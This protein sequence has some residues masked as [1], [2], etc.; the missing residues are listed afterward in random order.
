MSTTSI[1]TLF[2]H[3]SSVS[4]NCPGRRQVSVARWVLGV[5]LI[6]AFTLMPSLARAADSASPAAVGGITGRVKNAVTGLYLSNARVAV[7]GINSVA[8]TDNAGAYNLVGI[9]SGSVVLEVNYTDLDTQTVSVTVQPGHIVQQ[10]IELT[11]R[12]RYGLDA[13][14]L[15]LDP[16]VVGTNREADAE[17][18]AVNEQR[19]AANIKN[20]V[21]TDAM[22]D[23]V[24]QSAGEFL[25]YLPGVS[26]EYDAAEV[27]GISVRGIGSGMT[28]VESD[29]MSSTSGSHG[30]GRV[31][32]L[33][34]MSIN[35][36]SRIELSK[37]PTPSS[38]ADSL[39]GT[40]NM[41]SKTAFERD[42]DELRYGVNV[43]G[44]LK[45]LSLQRTP[46][47]YGDEKT[48]KILPGYDLD[49]TKLIG[50]NFGV[51]LTAMSSSSHT[52]FDFSMRTWSAAG[53][54]TNASFSQPYLQSVALQGSK[55]YRERSLYGVR[56][57]WRVT[58]HAVLTFG[59]RRS[60]SISARTGRNNI[61]FNVGT[62]GT[63]SVA[64][65]VAMA[66]GPTFTRGA[67]GRGS[68]A[69]SGT[70]QFGDIDGDTLD[71]HYRFDD[72]RWK[73][74]GSLLYGDSNARLQPENTFSGVSATLAVPV[75]V[76]YADI[77]D[78]GTPVIRVFNNAN[79]EVDFRDINNY[80][81][82]TASGGQNQRVQSATKS[83]KLDLG[84]RLGVFRFPLTVQAGGM[85]RLQLRDRR[86][87]P[88]V[89]TLNFVGTNHPATPYLG[90]SYREYQTLDFGTIPALSA[91]RG[92]RAFA[93][94]P[95]LFSQTAAQIV[96]VETA[97]LAA[98]EHVEEAVTSYYLQA[99]AQ[100]MNNRLRILTGVRFEGTKVAGEGLLFDPNLVYARSA[101][102]SFARNAQ[103]QRIRQADAGVAGSLDEARYIRQERGY[104]A[105]R[106]YEGYY[107]SLHFTY[108][109]RENAVLRLAYARTY[110]RPD[111]PNIIPNTTVNEA[112]L[113]E[114]QLDDPDIIKGT[115]TVR[116]TGLKPWT[117][118]NYDLSAE[119]YTEQGGLFSAGVFLKEIT[120]FFGTS[121]RVATLADLQA[122]GVDPRYVG[123]NLNT[124]FNAGDARVSGVEFNARQSLRQLGRWGRYFTVFANATRLKLEGNPYATFT[125]FVPKSA[126]WG[127]SY[128]WKRITVVSKW[129]YRGLVKGGAQP[130]L[131]PDAFQYTKAFTI[132]DL[133][134]AY[135][136]TGQLSLTFSVNNVFD[137]F[138]AKTM[139][140]GSETP[141][142]AQ[143]LQVGEYGPAFSLGVKGR[144]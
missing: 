110:G 8:F 85:Y 51:I 113:D 4:P 35:Q 78:S 141:G 83:G 55:R 40:V 76:E 66:Y 64:G 81:M 95:S 43:T 71:L 131:G 41:I 100:L 114:D 97:R 59:A 80:R 13:G 69:M 7:Q 36:V 48:Y 44:N 58:P 5:C 16:F 133:N 117:A 129:T 52:K 126:N 38:P 103:G 67:T 98:S 137:E 34:P 37:V 77:G 29:G 102:G 136:L 33:I 1:E 99:D 61:T 49:Y 57:D 91:V 42:S 75:R 121:V 140:Y 107:P 82:T 90:Q 27:V 70:N 109:I 116:N 144:F 22:G 10:D 21:A 122:L 30:T 132:M 20:V 138:N 84:R 39:A 53:T 134:V 14:A 6:A 86:T 96:A 46:H 94:D 28:S 118:D 17:A 3:R 62:T 128:N 9:R 25:K 68:V 105:R 50:K 120:D 142:Y 23:I 87:N 119:Y 15:R 112:D 130:L 101:D 12:A 92:Y 2:I 111:F 11:N 32:N 47:S 60:K 45:E 18:L 73:I 89:G 31:V 24:G 139:R 65:G 93:D 72:G 56:A 124:M 143:W 115:L 108:N 63:P 135:R 79:Q 74:S 125:A 104:A 127:F 106:T 88:L 123:W 26:A 19:Y 54:S